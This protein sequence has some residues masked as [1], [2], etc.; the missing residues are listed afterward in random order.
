MLCALLSE[1][2]IN[3]GQ[4]LQALGL[5]RL[6]DGA[7]QRPCNSKLWVAGMALFI[8]SSLITFS[9]LALASAS[10]LVPLESIQFLVK[11]LAEVHHHA[12]MDLLPEMSAKDLDQRY[13][14][15][16]DLSV[17]ED[18]CQVQ[19]HLESYI[20]IRPVNSWRPPECEASIRDLIQTCPLS[21][22]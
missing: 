9:A 15:C 6:G 5:E 21:I 8:V 13:L 17:H 7:L 11:Y 3:L 18:A 20:N 2:R 16:W 1:R 10:V 22:C 12:L 19:L 14:Q 4:N